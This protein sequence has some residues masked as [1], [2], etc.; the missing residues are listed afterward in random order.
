MAQKIKYLDNNVTYSQ[1][2]FVMV[3]VLNDWRIEVEIKGKSYPVLPMIGIYDM[4]RENGFYVFK[5]RD[6]N[7][8][9]STVDWLNLQVNNMK[10]VVN[11][12]GQWIPCLDTGIG[13]E[14]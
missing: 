9:E 1:G 4:L 13:D 2:P 14:I 8:I 10:I 7:M 11:E 5:G 3:E 12:F 6:E